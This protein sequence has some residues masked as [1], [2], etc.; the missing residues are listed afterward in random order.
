[1]SN[2]I[3]V[4]CNGCFDGLHPGHVFFLSFCRDYG[5]RLIVGINCD[6]YVLKKK[7]IPIPQD[8]RA[9]ALRSLGFID[10]V[11][12]FNEDSP[13]EFIKK[14]KPDIHCIGEEYKDSA[15][16]LP[17]CME[18]GIKVVFVPRVGTWSSTSIRGKSERGDQSCVSS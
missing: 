5:D 8:E 1:M 9:Y 3:L 18:M 11:V 14:Y 6:D 10:K 16:E 7:R 2:D 15:V 17:L 12:I 4:T 13:C